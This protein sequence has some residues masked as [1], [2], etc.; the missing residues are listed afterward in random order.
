MI[1]H[2]ASPHEE[3][4][5][6]VGNHFP[7]GTHGPVEVSLFIMYGNALLFA[8]AM[9]PADKELASKLRGRDAEGQF[10]A[11]L[12]KL[13]LIESGNNATSHSGIGIAQRSGFYGLTMCSLGYL[14]SGRR[15]YYIRTRLGRFPAMMTELD[16]PRINPSTTLILLMAETDKHHQVATLTH[17]GMP[18]HGARHRGVGS[19]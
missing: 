7:W 19:I 2:Q 9:Q 4:L 10:D 13:C 5:G 11:G 14:G 6:K 15:I 16:D 3:V 12:R 8:N 1:N 18:R 17:F